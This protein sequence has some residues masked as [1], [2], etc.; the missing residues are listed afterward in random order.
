MGF[1]LSMGILEF[2]PADDWLLG[3]WFTFSEQTLQSSCS[4][5]L[6]LN[7]EEYF[8]FWNS[9]W[10]GCHNVA[11][12]KRNTITARDPRNFV[13]NKELISGTSW[14]SDRKNDDEYEDK[15]C[16]QGRL[17]LFK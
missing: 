16:G 14:V 11:M 4:I 3:K 6:L 12:E 8:L 7:E 5:C 17:V 1:G 2:M 9:S 10:V 15:E 13:S